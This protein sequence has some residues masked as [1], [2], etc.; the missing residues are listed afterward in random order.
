MQVVA[1][2][3]EH[4]SG[5]PTA[6]RALGLEVVEHPLSVGDYEVSDRCLIERKS[7]RDLHASACS[8]R[9]WRQIGALRRACDW[10]YLLVE[11][12]PVYSGRLG[13]EGVRGLLLAVSDLGVSVIRSND[14]TDS[15]Y[16]IRRILIRRT[17]PVQRNRPP[18]A[19]RAKRQP[20]I[21]PAEEALAA[22]PGIS[23]DT[24]RR[25]L[26]HFGSLIDVLLAT[27]DDLTSVRGVGEKRAQSITDLA[28]G[29]LAIPA[30]AGMAS[31]HAT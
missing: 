27:S 4:R 24:A 18:Y 14:A 29:S 31:R 7:I 13:G 10:P 2:V 5:V 9:L 8:G 21:A 6:L 20:L 12:S 22:A 23:T 25:L 16:W 1:D 17:M 30:P 26:Q 3:F 11:G 19:H 28:R 15:A